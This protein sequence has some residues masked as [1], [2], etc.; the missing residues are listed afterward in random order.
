MRI[1]VLAFI[2]FPKGMASTNRIIAYCCGLHEGGHEV[3][4]YCLMQ[5]DS[6]NS[7]AYGNTE[8]DGCFNGVDF[9]YLS[10]KTWGD[11]N[12]FIRR[13]FYPY[14]GLRLCWRLIKEFQVRKPNVVIFSGTLLSLGMEYLYFLR[15]LALFFRFKLVLETNEF[16]HFFMFDQKRFF[17]LKMFGLRCMLRTLDAVLPIT[18]T[19]SLF[20]QPLCSKG[21]LFYLFPMLVSPDRYLNAKQVCSGADYIAYC[22]SMDGNKDGV[23]DLISAFAL[24]SGEFPALKLLLM[25]SAC[26]QRMALLRDKAQQLGVSDRVIFTGVVSREEMPQRLV[27]ARLLALAR[28]TSIQAQGGFPTKLGEYLLSGNPVVVTRVGDIPDY[29]KDSKNAFLANPDD[30]EDFAR[31]MRYVLTHSAEA[32]RVGAQ[33]RELALTVFNGNVQS[34]NLVTFFEQILNCGAHV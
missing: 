32:A 34:K 6:T 19:L 1:A 24:I 13:L 15:V 7:T 4:F 12:K 29:L 20:L 17:A 8:R 5:F 33:G 26:D 11:S 16:P 27:N 22:G 21:T 9:K 14:T 31:K 2:P 18:K 10:G 23:V 3:C 25:G 28:P 30:P